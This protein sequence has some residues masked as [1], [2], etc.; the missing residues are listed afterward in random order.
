MANPYQGEKI[1]KLNGI[2]YPMKVDL[3]VIVAFKEETGRDFMEVAIGALNAFAQADH[4]ERR[5]IDRA[6]H[7]TKYVPLSEA[8]HLFYL[9]AHKCN[10]QVTFDEMQE[11]VLMEGPLEVSG[12]N[13]YPVQFVDLCSFAIIG[14]SDEQT[15]KNSPE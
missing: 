6:A 1:I 5:G 2:N 13:S 8:A 15:K 10:S 12:R 7:L 4:D 9:A 3:S 11:A 14:P